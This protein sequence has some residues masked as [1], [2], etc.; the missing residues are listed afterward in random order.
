MQKCPLPFPFR[1]Q[2]ESLRSTIPGNNTWPP[3][4]CPISGFIIAKQLIVN[5]LPSSVPLMTTDT[6]TEC[7]TICLFDFLNVWKRFYHVMRIESTSRLG[8]CVTKRPYAT[9]NNLHPW[10][11]KFSMFDVICDESV[12]VVGDM[13]F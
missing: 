9:P 1:C 7:M 11:F 6:T 5:C 3:R 13:N 8:A 10:R 4:S 12:R 2:T